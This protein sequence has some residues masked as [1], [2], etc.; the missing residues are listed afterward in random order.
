MF[1]SAMKHE[2]QAILHQ[3]RDYESPEYEGAAHD[4]IAEK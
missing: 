4:K 3:T 1:A 2:L